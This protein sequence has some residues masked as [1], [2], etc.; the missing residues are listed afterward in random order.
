MTREMTPLCCEMTPLSHEMTREMTALCH[1]LTPLSHEMTR[2]MTAL[3]HE[4]TPLSHEM[5][6]SGGRERACGA[7]A[8][9]PPLHF[10]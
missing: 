10:F 1:E 6:V 2:E 5:M 4:L 3:C 8:G 9:G 7:Q